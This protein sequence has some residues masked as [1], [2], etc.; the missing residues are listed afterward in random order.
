MLVKYLICKCFKFHLQLVSS[1]L[2]Q[3]LSLFKGF[4]V[5]LHPRLVSLDFTGIE[6][7]DFKILEDADHILDL[8]RVI[9]AFRQGD[10]DV[11]IRNVTLLFGQS[12]QIA[13]AIIQA[14]LGVVETLLL[15]R[16]LWLHGGGLGSSFFCGCFLCGRLR[17][18]GGLF[19]FRRWGFFRGSF[20]LC[21][22]EDG[23]G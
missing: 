20:L 3:F 14:C 8:F 18:S 17:L 10:I 4:L 15:L 7:V 16:N 19:L 23:E 12:D 11:F 21:W 13:D 22:H 9:Y 5:L 1:L 2:E 6:D